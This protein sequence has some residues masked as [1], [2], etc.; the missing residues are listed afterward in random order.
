MRLLHK[1]MERGKGS[2][3]GNHYPGRKG[4]SK[5]PEPLVHLKGSI[6]TQVVSKL[7]K[8]HTHKDS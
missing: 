3:H 1:Q 4:V 2:N 5:G 8:T 6:T 7:S